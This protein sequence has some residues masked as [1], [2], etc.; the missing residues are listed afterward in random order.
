MNIYINVLSVLTAS[1]FISNFSPQFKCRPVCFFLKQKLIGP[2]H[3]QHYIG[4]I[5]LATSTL[6]KSISPV[7]MKHKRVFNYNMWQISRVKR[8]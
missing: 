7:F 3:R 4:E 1:N 2:I 6:H 5:R 8:I